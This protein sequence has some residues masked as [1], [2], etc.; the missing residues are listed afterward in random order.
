[1]RILFL[2]QF[3]ELGGAQ[4]CLLNLLP[5][6]CEVHAAAP[7][8]GPLFQLLEQRAVTVHRLSLGDYSLGRK[9][10]GDAIR[11]F[12]D[13]PVVE[14][15][16]RALVS[17]LRPDLLYVNGPRL[18]PAVARAA[19]GCAVLYHCH[20]LPTA[21]SGRWLVAR[22]LDRTN[23][24]VIAASRYLARQWNGPARVIYGGV[25]GPPPGWS[26]AAETGPPRVG[27]IG[28]ITPQKGQK[29]F[30]MA[31]A[32]LHKDWPDAEFLLCGDTLFGDPG[33]ESYKEELLALAPACVRFLGWRDDIYEVLRTLD[34]LVLPSAAE[35]GI[36]MVILEAFAAGVPVLATPVGGV[37]E[38]LSDGRN[39]FLLPSPSASV[40]ERRLRKLLPRRELLAHTAESAHRLWREKFTAE[41]YR[42]EVW[43]TVASSV[44]L[45]G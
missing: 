16:I 2:D 20:N 43:E 6:S 39:G 42:N 23:A 15:E 7:G 9:S 5:A 30:V 27:L 12:R 26:R 24:T 17:R 32:K 4:R 1:M 18:M 40:I 3:S 45:P 8:R 14:A 29:E 10:L 36:P 13:L 21:R 25:E 11:F 35:G 41:R 22:A 33:A 38:I 28:R 37:P 31:A 19:G 44:R 34:L